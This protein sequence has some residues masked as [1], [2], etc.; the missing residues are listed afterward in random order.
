M[1]RTDTRH[2]NPHVKIANFGDFG[3]VCM[4]CHEPLEDGH[5]YVE[6][7]TAAGHNEAVCTQ[8][9]LTIL[10]MAATM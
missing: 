10:E 1:A 6:F 4:D 5:P 3:A 7:P 8:C 2:G 9:G